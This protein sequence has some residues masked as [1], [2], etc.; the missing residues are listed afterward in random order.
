[1][2]QT[3]ASVKAAREDLARREAVLRDRLADPDFLANRGLGN[4]VG[5]FLFCYDPA[6][7]LELRDT[8]ARLMRDSEN[9]ALPCRLVERNLYDLLLAICDERRVSAAIPRMEAKRGTAAL[10]E[11]LHKTASLDAFAEA[12]DYG[13]HEPGDVVLITGVG[14]VYPH[15]RTH[16]LLD[17][18]QHLF[19]DVPLVVAY[20]GLY[21]GQSMRL[22]A[23]S[24]GRGLDDGNYYRAFNLV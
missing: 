18:I 12:I 4:E 2:A 1:M 7:E 6:L 22:F 24:S 3:P 5:I 19:A 15:L 9:G 14:E 16:A 8:V 20:P 23:G 11:Q 21:D 17:N 10:V 13:P